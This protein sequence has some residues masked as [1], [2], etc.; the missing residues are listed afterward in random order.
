MIGTVALAVLQNPAV[1]A[2]TWVMGAME[3]FAP[4][5]HVVDGDFIGIDV[6]IMDEAAALIGVELD[7]RPVPWKRMLLDFEAGK[8]D[9]VFQLTPTQ[10]RFEKWH[11]AGPM[12]TTR[13]V[14][15][16]RNDSPIE[17]IRS[18]ADLEGLVVGLVAGF[19]YEEEFDRDPGIRREMSHDDFNNIRKLLLG[20]SDV[21]VGGHATIAYT[22]RE[23][24]AW[25][26]LRVLPTPLVELGRYAAFPRTPEGAEKARRLQQA[27]DRLH[28]S[29]RIEEIMRTAL[30]R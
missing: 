11:L 24:N 1:Q 26:K 18:R 12:R 6:Q 5:N 7:H 10:A 21:I 9:G 29:G 15:I 23:L 27:L 30:N 17:D 3:D 2:E 19:T 14:F 8:F 22:A 16:T 28:D 20:R 25:D 4:F 13:S